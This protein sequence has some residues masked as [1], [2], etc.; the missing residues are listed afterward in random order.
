MSP[1]IV[2]E[3]VIDDVVAT[4]IPYKYPFV[5]L[6]WWVGPKGIGWNMHLPHAFFQYRWPM[7]VNMRDDLF[8][9]LDEFL[10]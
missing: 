8:C 6:V 7:C 4:R 3:T 10:L 5:V 2:V 1:E 9:S